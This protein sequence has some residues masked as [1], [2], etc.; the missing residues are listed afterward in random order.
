MNSLQNPPNS[1]S[2]QSCNWKQLWTQWLCTKLH[3]DSEKLIRAEKALTSKH[4]SEIEISPGLIEANIW[5]NEPFKC[6]L[7]LGKLNTTQSK[8]FVESISQSPL[9]YAAIRSN[10]LPTKLSTQLL[11]QEHRF[12]V[13]CSCPRGQNALWQA[14]TAHECCRHGVTLLVWLGTLFLNDPFTLVALRGLNR[15]ELLAKTRTR[16]DE[17]AGIKSTEQT[18]LNLAGSQPETISALRAWRRKKTP[19]AVISSVGETPKQLDKFYATPAD[20]GLDAGELQALIQDALERAWSM[21]AEGKPSFSDIG[22]GADVVR[23]C[24]QDLSLLD[25]AAQ[26]TGLDRNELEAAALAWQLGGYSGFR[27]LRERWQ[28]NTTLMQQ[29]HKIIKELLQG[30]QHQDQVASSA[31]TSSAVEMPNHKQRAS[32]NFEIGEFMQ[33][34]AKHTTPASG[35]TPPCWQVSMSANTI[36]ATPA[37]SHAHG[38]QLRYDQHG[39]WWRFEFNEKLGWCLS[40]GP[41]IEPQLLLLEDANQPNAHQ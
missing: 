2:H 34:K 11:V 27:A 10:R 6:S 40:Q 38:F 7:S 20:S 32:T 22:I 23:R 5:Q 1:Q 33:E 24:A 4:L 16:R 13:S 36:T 31:P 25:K 12:S 29:A 30:T 21:L 18:E 35:S 17:I 26:N 3:F 19:Q 15:A 41:E 28:P 39:D 14:N 8:N 9:D 37:G